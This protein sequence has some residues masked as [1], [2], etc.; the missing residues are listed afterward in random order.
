[1]R[2][3]FEPAQSRASEPTFRAETVFSL[4]SETMKRRYSKAQR[5]LPKVDLIAIS[6]G[7]SSLQ[8]APEYSQ[9]AYN[10][11]LRREVCLGNYFATSTCRFEQMGSSQGGRRSM[12]LLMEKLHLIKGYRELTLY[13][14]V[15]IADKYL[16]TLARKAMPAPEVVTLGA[17]S[18]LLAAKL[19]ESMKP[20]MRNMAILINDTI[21]AKIELKDL[22]T[23]E[24]QILNELEFDLQS[25]TSINFVERFCQ[26]F[27]LDEGLFPAQSASESSTF[28]QEVCRIART[29]SRYALSETLFLQFRPSQVAAAAVL[30]ALS[31]AS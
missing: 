8:M 13:L 19:N 2:A 22:V 16:S 4:Y 27:Y 28:A 29:L 14:A 7:S 17:V 6:K 11:M 3:C 1:M 23:L 5:W 15:N 25:E 21:S 10:E 31:A 20:N 24:K 18:L 30:L 26:L 9:S 12:V